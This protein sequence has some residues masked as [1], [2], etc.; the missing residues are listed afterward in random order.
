MFYTKCTQSILRYKNRVYLDSE[1]F[2]A[3]C[4]FKN[5]SEGKAKNNFIMNKLKTGQHKII[6]SF[7]NKNKNLCIGEFV[8]N[9]SWRKLEC[10]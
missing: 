9:F 7:D 6:V 10:L 3:L 5:N 1:P 4:K 8:Y 2:N